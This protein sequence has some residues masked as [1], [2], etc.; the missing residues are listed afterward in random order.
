MISPPVGNNLRTLAAPEENFGIVNGLINFVGNNLK[1]SEYVR[2]VI[3]YSHYFKD[4]K[5]TISREALTKVYQV[6]LLIM[7]EEIIPAKYFKA[8]VNVKGLY[9]IRVMESGNIYRI[10]YCFDEDCLVILLS[11]F[12]KKT[13]K[14]PQKEIEK[15]ERLMNEYLEKK[16]RLHKND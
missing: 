10:F 3:T 5:R 4:F 6:L 7:T 8:I 1:K 15:A 16:H 14:T 9:E 11:G 13:Q 12:Q 2:R